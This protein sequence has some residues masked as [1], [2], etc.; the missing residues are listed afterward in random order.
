M[1]GVFIAL[2]GLTFLLKN[3]DVIS[4]HVTNIIWPSLIILAG[5][6]KVV[7]G[8]CKCCDEG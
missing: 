8:I 4:D 1:V 3:L 6:K 2:F 5:V 7:R